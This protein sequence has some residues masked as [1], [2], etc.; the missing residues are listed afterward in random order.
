MPRLQQMLAAHPAS[1]SFV[2]ERDALLRCLDACFECTQSCTSCADAC[3]SEP[4]VPSLARCITLNLDC[5][6]ICDATGRTLLRQT[7]GDAQLLRAQV[8]ACA[9]A[10]RVCAEE[11]ERHAAMGMEHCRLCAESCRACAEACDAVLRAFTA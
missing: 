3:L 5:A 11:C 10:C 7:Q 2:V 1:G 4:D 9:E 8:E 6:D